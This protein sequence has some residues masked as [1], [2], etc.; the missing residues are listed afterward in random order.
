MDLHA[1]PTT[2]NPFR[3]IEIRADADAFYK[4]KILTLTRKAYRII[5]GATA[6]IAR[7]MSAVFLYRRYVALTC[8]ISSTCGII[9]TNGFVCRN[10]DI[11]FSLS[12][13]HALLA[14]TSFREFFTPLTTKEGTYKLRG[15]RRHIILSRQTVNI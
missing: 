9:I 3:L 1:A 2:V 8:G 5:F 7:I 12:Y 10:A 11:S 6:N 13:R 4:D 15:M 14:N